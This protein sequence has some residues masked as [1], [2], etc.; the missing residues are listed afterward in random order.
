[1]RTQFFIFQHMKKIAH[2]TSPRH[3]HW[4]F[5][6][7]VECIDHFEI[8]ISESTSRVGCLMSPKEPSCLAS[9]PQRGPGKAHFR[10]LGAHKDCRELLHQDFRQKADHLHCHCC[11]EVRTNGGEGCI[12]LHH[13]RR[14]LCCRRFGC[15]DKA[16]NCRRHY[17]NHVLQLTVPRLWCHLCLG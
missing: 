3:Q 10:I 12:P 17:H 11:L 9:P 4:V 6:I 7:T 14:G 16:R 2:E 13:R 5:F 15:E 1:M 8:Q